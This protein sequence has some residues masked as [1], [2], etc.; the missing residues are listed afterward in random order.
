MSLT[1]VDLRRGGVDRHSWTPP[2]DSS[3]TYENEHWWDGVRYFVDDPWFVQL[4]EDGV[5]VARV[6]LD[7][8]GGIN[9]DCAD[10][11]N[12]GD[13]RLEI[14]FVEV[15]S[16]AHARGVGTRVVRALEDRHPG[17]RL[18]AYSEDADHFWVSVGW[19][20]FYRLCRPP[21]RT[22]FVQPAR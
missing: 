3:I 13:E 2:F 1:L 9:P 22:L 19:E 6:E 12:L 16:A 4:L 5:E 14:Q 10:V 21:A 20:P 17:R 8:P 7:D 18:F 15:A 11:P